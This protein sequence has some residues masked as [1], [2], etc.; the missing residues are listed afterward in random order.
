MTRLA[1]TALGSKLFPKI[2]PCIK[3]RGHIISCWKL[4]LPNHIIILLKFNMLLCRLELFI[5]RSFYDY[6]YAWP[7]F[8]RECSILHKDW[9]V[10]QKDPYF[11]WIFLIEISILLLNADEIWY[12]FL[13]FKSFKSNTWVSEKILEF[14]K[15]L[16]IQ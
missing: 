15:C 14:F 7:W 9:N 5:I 10:P 16:G 4:S 8:K 13:I 12:A 3:F 2:A 1:K 11:I 6:Q